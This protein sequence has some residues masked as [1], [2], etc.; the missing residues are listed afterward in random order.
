MSRIQI[1]IS[2]GFD[3]IFPPTFNGKLGGKEIAEGAD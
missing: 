2:L 3:I 1:L